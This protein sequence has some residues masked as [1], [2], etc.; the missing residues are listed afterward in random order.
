MLIV[1]P[2]YTF[3]F[4]QLKVMLKCLFSNRLIANYKKQWKE[5]GYQL[6]LTLH[7]LDV[8]NSE[9]LLDPVFA[10]YLEIEPK[11]HFV[12]YICLLP[13]CLKKGKYLQNTHILHF[14]RS[15]CFVVHLIFSQ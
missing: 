12:K 9:R 11:G 5:C 14:S 15:A 3:S 4:I 10:V 13:F 2:K 1:L 8:N 7:D 6:M